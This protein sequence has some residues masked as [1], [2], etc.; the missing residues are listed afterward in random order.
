MSK[1]MCKGENGREWFRR[2]M[3]QRQWRAAK[4]ITYN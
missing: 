1:I 4:D 3:K 2:K